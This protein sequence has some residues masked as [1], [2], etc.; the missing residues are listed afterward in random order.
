MDI[1][2][3]TTVLDD[4]K[5]ESGS[6]SATDNVDDSTKIEQVMDLVKS[7]LNKTVREE[8]EMLKEKITK[9]LE[10]IQ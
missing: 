4:A 8:V 5:E 1:N 7:H 6:I 9:L 3:L 2:T 10:R